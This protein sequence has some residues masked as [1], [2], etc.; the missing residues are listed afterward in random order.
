MKLQYPVKILQFGEGNFLR[1]FVEFMVE[2]LNERTAFNGSVC[3]VKA[4]P[5]G[6][7]ETLREQD[8][9]YTLVNR[10][11]QNGEVVDRSRIIH[12]VSDAVCAYEDYEDFM[13]YAKCPTL[14]F[15]VSN[16]TE[17]G[18][19]YG[20]DDRFEDRPPKEYP[21][22]LTKFLYERWQYFEGA[23]DKGLYMLPCELIEENGAALEACVMKTAQGW[24][25]PNDFIVWLQT[26][27]AFC[28][29]LVDRIVTGYPREEA[30]ELEKALG[31]TDKLLDVGEPFALW[32]LQ[33]KKSLSSELPLQEAGLPAVFAESVLPYRERKVRI[34]NGAHTSTVLAG[35]LA[36]KDI[37]RECME[38]PTIFAFMKKVVLDEV[39]PVLPGG[40]DHPE[41]FAQSV[42]ERF[43]N[44]FIAHRLLSISLNSV[45]KWKARCLC[46]FKDYV[47]HYKQLPV[48]LTFSFAALIAFY[49]GYERNGHAAYELQDSDEVLAFF[50]E[51]NEKALTYAEFAGAVAGNVDFW[52]EDMTAYDGFVP[53]VSAYLTDILENGAKAAMEKI[54]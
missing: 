16:T 27:C 35:F 40:T 15:I 21:S 52:G 26:A 2:E 6:S 54:L 18:I 45:S 19:V 8:Y 31:Y 47:A 33:E 9:T 5:F 48:A 1:A 51:L 17:A 41:V 53:A 24:G 46:S 44:P 7:L 13:A 14:R 25:L 20:A 36:G 30:D 50:K 32:A 3:I 4:V 38:D 29:T 11:K 42:F 23:A 12:C 49:M 37:V 10:G 34:L 43:A 39:V 22:K 28:S